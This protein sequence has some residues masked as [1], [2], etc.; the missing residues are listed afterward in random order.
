MRATAS[1][2]PLDREEDEDTVDDSVSEEDSI[3]EEDW[4]APPNGPPR[5]VPAAASRSN[6]LPQLRTQEEIRE[7]R[8]QQLISGAE[9]HRRI[10]GDIATELGRVTQGLNNVVTAINNLVRQQEAHQQEICSL[11]RTLLV[12][13]ARG[14][15]PPS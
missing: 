12:A 7:D 1:A 13:L 4:F 8:I 14:N 6:G 15:P 5:H 11:L 3:S 9:E 2:A 10:M